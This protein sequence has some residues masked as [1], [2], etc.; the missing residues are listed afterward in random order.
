M[1]YNG[2]F[3]SG[4]NSILYPENMYNEFYSYV[5]TG[6][7]EFLDADQSQ[8]AVDWFTEQLTYNGEQAQ[9]TFIA[10]SIESSELYLNS[11]FYVEASTRNMGYQINFVAATAQDCTYF[12]NQVSPAITD[13]AG[14]C[15]LYDF[16]DLAT[17]RM[18]VDGD[19]SMKNT[20]ATLATT[21]GITTTQMAS[22]YAVTNSD[23]YG[24]GSVVG[25][26]VTGSFG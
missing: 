17:M 1:S 5:T 14:L 15:A 9:G 25:S 8:M 23:P 2:G 16:S 7:F 10:K 21:L 18:F 26:T 4:T 3:Q 11:N 6:T 12:M 19:A 24:D 13:V 20:Q 22:F